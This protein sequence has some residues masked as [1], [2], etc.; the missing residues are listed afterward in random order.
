MK[1]RVRFLLLAAGISAVLLL[2]KETAWTEVQTSPVV[3][4][5]APSTATAGSRSFT[6]TVNGLYFLRSSI[7]RWNDEDRPTTYVGDKVLR[8]EI[9][10]GDVAWAGTALVSVFNP[11]PT[12]HYGASNRLPFY[13]LEKSPGGTEAR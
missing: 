11:Y 1:L 6:L 7:V 3:G 8:A 12:E 9:P 13:I 5:I 2:V 4:A 10:A